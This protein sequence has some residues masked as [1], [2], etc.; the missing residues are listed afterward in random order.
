MRIAD[1]HFGYDRV[2]PAEVVDHLRE[3]FKATRG[4]E[5]ALVW[6]DD[7]AVAAGERDRVL[8]VGADGE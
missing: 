4:G 3:D 6:R 8:E 7:H 2:E 5:V 1:E